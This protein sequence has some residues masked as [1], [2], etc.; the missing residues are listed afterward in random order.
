LA[1]IIQ[2]ETIK[3]F[4]DLKTWLSIAKCS[5]VVKKLS[6]KAAFGMNRPFVR[7]ISAFWANK[8]HFKPLQPIWSKNV[9]SNLKLHVKRRILD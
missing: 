1:K 2:L 8:G 4:P 7:P 6:R 3:D 5:F 9:F